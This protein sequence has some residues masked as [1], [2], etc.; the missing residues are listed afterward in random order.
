MDKDK[1]KYVVLSSRSSSKLTETVNSYIAEGWKV[2]GS[3]QVLTKHIS[4]ER[5]MT[6]HKYENEYS[7]TLIRD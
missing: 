2:V 1:L 7:Q 5:A 3:H 4:V 6:Q